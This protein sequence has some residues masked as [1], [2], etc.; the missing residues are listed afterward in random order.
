MARLSRGR[1]AHRKLKKRILLVCEGKETEPNYF[2]ALRREQEVRDNFTVKVVPGRGKTPLDAARRAVESKDRAERNSSE[3][4]FDDVWCVLDVEET[5]KNPY[6][7]DAR[8]LAKENGIRIV[9][10]NPAFEVW[11]LA[12]FERTAKSFINGDKVIEQLHKHW[13][14]A[15]RRKYE[16]N[17]E[18]IY[19]RLRDRTAEAIGNARLVREVDFKDT[20]DIVD[21]DSA[22]E[23]YQVVAILLGPGE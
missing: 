4:E 22:T 8:K 23:V 15:F 16:K 19:D 13:Q 20:S 7:A 5:G 6:L 17:D 12:H 14:P 11:I 18:K 21:C 2:R 10:S 3:F 1:L 9:L